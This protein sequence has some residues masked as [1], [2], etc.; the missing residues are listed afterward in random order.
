M[1]KKIY[2]CLFVLWG[3]T[4]SAQEMTISG[5]VIDTNVYM[6]VHNAKTYLI[7]LND[8]VIVNYQ[9]TNEYGSFEYRVP[10]SNYRLTITHPSFNKKEFV[11]AGSETNKT[12]D[13]G[14][15]SLADK[16]DYL[17]SVVIYA[18]KDPIFVQRHD[19][20]V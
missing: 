20:F 11:F 6:P 7:N 5:T 4:L 2:T 19:L 16:S 8:S 14:E 15:F 9:N 1:I 3:F 18:Y 13:L 10:I 17:E 12:F